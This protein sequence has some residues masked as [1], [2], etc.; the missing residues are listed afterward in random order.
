M[1]PPV[2]NE[3]VVSGTEV[4]I[5]WVI[6]E[7]NFTAAAFRIYYEAS[8]RQESVTRTLDGGLRSVTLHHLYPVTTYKFLMVTIAES[9]L[10]SNASESVEFTTADPGKPIFGHTGGFRL[11]T[12]P[13]ESI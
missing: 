13:S 3:T 2:V 6:T 5:S 12:H 8:E 4:R 10:F 11:T 9:G 7:S 1:A